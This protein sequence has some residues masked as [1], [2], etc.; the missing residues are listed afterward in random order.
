MKCHMDTRDYESEGTPAITGHSWFPNVEVCRECH[1]GANSFNVPGAQR[2]IERLLEDLERKL[3]RQKNEQEEDYIYAKF[4]YGFV[5]A[6]ASMGVHNYDYA[7]QLLEDSIEFYT[8]SNDSVGP[9]NVS[10]RR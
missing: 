2:R 8:P 1:P 10:R 3:E 4:N 7:K 6:D 9:R 5:E